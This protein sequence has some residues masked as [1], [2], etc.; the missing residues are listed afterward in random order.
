MSFKEYFLFLDLFG[1]QVHF[2]INNKKTFN[3]YFG[4]IMSI[5][6]IIFIFIFTF[7]FSLQLINRSKP[8]I[9]G[10]TYFDKYPQP[11]L[12]NDNFIF[13]FSLQFPNY[14]NYID[15]SIY[16]IKAYL[17]TIETINGQTN[18]TYSPIN[19]YR[20]SNFTF[21]ILED[22]F[23]TLP[24]HDLYCIDLNGIE[25][26][27]EYK[28]NKW[29]YVQIF[30]NKC[31]NSTSDIVCKSKVE[32][33]KYLEGGYAGIFMTDNLFQP[34]NFKHPLQTYGKNIFSSLNGN[35]YFEYW[36]YLKTIVIKSDN[37][38]IFDKIETKNF[39]SFEQS[40]ITSD[41]RNA[42]ST[43]LNIILRESST[44]EIYERSYIKLQEICA[45][46]GGIS[47]ALLFIF[48]YLVNLFSNI[49]YKNYILQFFN[50]DDNIY[51]IKKNS[52]KKIIRFNKNIIHP[53]SILINNKLNIF[54]NKK[55]ENY[56][57]NN[58]YRQNN[59]KDLSNISLFN[60]KKKSQALNHYFFNE[61]K[62]NKNLDNLILNLNNS[63]VDNYS[64]KNLETSIYL[65]ILLKEKNK[66]NN[67]ICFSYILYKSKSFYAIKNIYLN[68]RKISFI[69]DIISYIKTKHELKLIEKKLLKKN[70]Q[71]LLSKIYKF[72][73]DFI[74]EENAYENFLKK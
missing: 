34:N 66:R 61:N 70:E 62:K 45:N 17:T 68:Y 50:L 33:D 40:L 58:C 8:T 56:Y 46:V 63:T 5:L 72:D 22:Y 43:F 67:I 42:S 55:E 2:T 6:Y 14:T 41:S 27:G 21:N 20:C 38:W 4:S 74:L 1:N 54:N 69:F 48:Q 30:F 59:E 9:L 57:D 35:Y 7:Y 15:E 26:Q 3:T 23:M 60:K 31:D 32:I 10:T 53:K 18:Q 51:K 65:K 49:L 37:G 36:V 39:L 11:F 73:Y 52:K 47:K 71:Q 13:T 64:V 19:I 29:V 16:N 24:I 44:R 12:I 25:F 28:R